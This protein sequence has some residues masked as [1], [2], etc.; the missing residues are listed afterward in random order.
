LPIAE[1]RNILCD[2]Q[3]SGGLLIAV[4]KEAAQT[5]ALLL[6]SKGLYAEP[7]GELI[8]K[9]ELSVYINE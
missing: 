1:Q 8:D 5:V 7:I 2:P 4:T 6:K 3:T 9:A